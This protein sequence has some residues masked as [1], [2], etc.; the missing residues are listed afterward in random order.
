MKKYKFAG[1]T[2]GGQF[3]LPFIGGLYA[4]GQGFFPDYYKDKYEVNGVTMVV[5]RG[6]GNSAIP[7]RL[8]NPP[9]IVV[10]DI[11]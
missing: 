8:F 7:L 4:S 9:E 11:G 3:N 5:S 2:H 10:V 1:H 6:L